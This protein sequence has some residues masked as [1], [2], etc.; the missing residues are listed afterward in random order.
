M[1]IEEAYPG[2]SVPRQRIQYYSQID[3]VHCFGVQMLNSQDPKKSQYPGRRFAEL[4]QLWF[5]LE[6]LEYQVS[7]PK[8]MV[9]PE[10]ELQFFRATEREEES[11]VEAEILM[12]EIPSYFQLASHKY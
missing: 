12:P 11:Q 6:K 3:R 9:Y 5:L 1:E 4:S 2:S 8:V 10:Q 7:V